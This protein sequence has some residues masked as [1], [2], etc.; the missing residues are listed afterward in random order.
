MYTYIQIFIF[1]YI[2]KNIFI[3][4]IQI[5]IQGA[6]MFYLCARTGQVVKLKPYDNQFGKFN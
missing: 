5:S 1:M 6:N 2:Y 3:Y 4:T